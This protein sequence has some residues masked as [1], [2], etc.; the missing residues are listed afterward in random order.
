[1]IPRQEGGNRAYHVAV[2]RGIVEQF[3]ERDSYELKI[4]WDSK[5]ELAWQRNGVYVKGLFRL[6]YM[7]WNVWVVFPCKVDG[8]PR[9]N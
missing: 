7:R 4:F 9:T 8:M 6:C 2:C 3:E 5:H 1:M